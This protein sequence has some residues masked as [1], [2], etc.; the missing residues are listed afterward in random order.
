MAIFKAALTR[1]KADAEIDPAI[2]LELQRKTDARVRKM[3]DKPSTVDFAAVRGATR[4]HKRDTAYRV[5]S[6][7]FLDGFETSCRIADQSYSGFR[8]VMN[9]DVEC[10]DEFALNIPTLRFIG[11]VRK[12]WQNGRETGVSILRWNDCT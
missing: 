2:I 12:S 7:H 3:S 9:S 5:A 1:K 4:M 8:L 10:P 6:A 11:I